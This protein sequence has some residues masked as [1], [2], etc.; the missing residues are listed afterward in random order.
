LASTLHERQRQ[1]WRDLRLEP[2]EASNVRRALERLARQIVKA[3]RRVISDRSKAE[4]QQPEENEQSA[5][6]KLRA[7]AE[8]N[9]ALPRAAMPIGM[10]LTPPGIC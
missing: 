7:Q 5:A 10:L 3:R 2:F 8:R 4:L 1:D 6:K 9:R